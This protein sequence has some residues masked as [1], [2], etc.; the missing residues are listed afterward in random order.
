ML[1]HI[2]RMLSKI[3]AGPRRTPFTPGMTVRQCMDIQ[4]S[5]RNRGG[6]HQW[7]VSSFCVLDEPS[8]LL[9]E[10]TAELRGYLAREYQFHG[11]GCH[12]SYSDDIDSREAGSQLLVS[13][14]AM[15]TMRKMFAK[16]VHPSRG[17]LLCT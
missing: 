14:R 15:R 4:I 7:E 16:H 17:S 9:E 11:P 2:V 13:E 10:A 6:R 12:T 8:I 5:L 3:L 1:G